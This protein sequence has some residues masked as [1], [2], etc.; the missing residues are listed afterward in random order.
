MDGN[1]PSMKIISIDSFDRKKFGG[2]RGRSGAN[3][4]VGDEKWI[5]ATFRRRGENKLTGR[6]MA[7]S[8]ALM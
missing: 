4:L 2:G 6:G 8:R 3:N 7:V 1:L 5:R